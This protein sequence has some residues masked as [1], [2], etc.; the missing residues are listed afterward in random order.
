MKV[1][2]EDKK[3]GNKVIDLPVLLSFGEK[4]RAV[5]EAQDLTQKEVAKNMG[6]CNY[7]AYARYEKMQFAP[8]AETKKKL[9]DALRVDVSVLSSETEDSIFDY[10][11]NWIRG[12]G[13]DGSRHHLQTETGRFAAAR[14][15]MEDL[16]EAGQRAAIDLLELV[17]RIPEYKREYKKE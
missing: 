14:I 8:K 16:N 10:E 12:I 9:A 4:L 2:I 1:I 6:F 15:L 7:Q 3:N 11:Y 17:S 13:L 5:R